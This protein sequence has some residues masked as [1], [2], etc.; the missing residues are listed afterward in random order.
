[1]T[2]TVSFRVAYTA[3]VCFVAIFAAGLISYPVPT[4]GTGLLDLAPAPA[5]NRALKGDR[6]PVARPAAG[7]EEPHAPARAGAGLR[8]PLGCERA[9]SPIA[10][11]RLADFFRRCMV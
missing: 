3:I 9:F 4:R 5:V 11:P 8:I 10:S 7:F 2:D 6:L 1:M